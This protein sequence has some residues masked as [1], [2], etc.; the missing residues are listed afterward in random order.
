MGA[1]EYRPACPFVR[2]TWAPFVWPPLPA[3]QKLR[4]LE[5]APGGCLW[6]PARGAR[7]RAHVGRRCT[8]DCGVTQ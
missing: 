2:A 3:P 8:P 5:A 1:P 7:S 4:T 6:R